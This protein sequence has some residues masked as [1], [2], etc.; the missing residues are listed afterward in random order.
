MYLLLFLSVIIAYLLSLLGRHG[1]APSCQ[2][3]SKAL[4]CKWTGGSKLI[5]KVLHEIRA[6]EAECGRHQQAKRK[7]GGIVELDATTMGSFVR[8]SR[9]FHFQLFGVVRRPD[10]QGRGLAFNIFPMQLAET[11]IKAT[12]PV[13]DLKRVNDCKGLQCIDKRR[14]EA[15]VTDGARLYPS[16]GDALQLPHFHVNHSK[17]VWRRQFLRGPKPALQAHSGTVD[18]MWKQMQEVMPSTLRVSSPDGETKVN[19]AL[20]EYLFQFSLRWHHEGNFQCLKQ[21]VGD[22]LRTKG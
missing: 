12:P 3:V 20:V 21:K 19:P 13:E 16:I 11:V 9:K 6:V 15:I 4:G 18:N 14:C 7:L 17:G 2:L 5:R 10:D 22:F 1:A 8:K